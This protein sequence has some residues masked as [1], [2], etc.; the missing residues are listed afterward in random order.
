MSKKG[1]QKWYKGLV[2]VLNSEGFRYDEV[3]EKDFCP[4]CAKEEEED[5]NE[6]LREYDLDDF[7]DDF[8]ED[9]E[10]QNMDIWC[11]ECGTY[12]GWKIKED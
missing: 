1:R 12:R 6:D 11:D 3:E 7:E 2:D 8:K 9:A 5:G 4:P 10:H